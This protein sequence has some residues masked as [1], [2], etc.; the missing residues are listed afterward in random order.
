MVKLI[1]GGALISYA[2]VFYNYM[3]LITGW[4]LILLLRLD[5]LEEK[6]NKKKK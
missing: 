1:L 6:I 4:S 3:A 2:I 5:V